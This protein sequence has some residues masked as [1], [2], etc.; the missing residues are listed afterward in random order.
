MIVIY[1]KVYNF[2]KGDECDYS[3]RGSHNYLP[4]TYLPTYLPSSTY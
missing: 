3:F 1:F 2:V 4:S